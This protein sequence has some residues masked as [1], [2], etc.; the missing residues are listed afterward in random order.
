MTTATIVA[1]K[2][3]GCL[4]QLAWFALFGWWLGQAWVAAAWFLAATVIG[5][6]LAVMMLNRVPEVITLRGE[7]KLLVRSWGG[8]TVVTE[9]PQYNLLLRALYFLLV[10]WWASAVW[11]ETAYALPQVHR[12]RPAFGILGV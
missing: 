9:M 4:V 12:H 6:P 10:G 5:L 3:P 2:N 11:I 7:S 8:R 1:K